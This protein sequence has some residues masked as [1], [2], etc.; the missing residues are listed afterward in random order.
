MPYYEN[1]TH[2]KI[3]DWL[4]NGHIHVFD[5]LPEK[6]EIHKVPREYICNVCA[7]LLGDIFTKWVREKIDDRNA[8]MIEKKDL[9]IDI[10]DEVLKALQESTSVSRKCICTSKFLTF[11]SQ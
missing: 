2:G 7:S 6:R 3:S 9:N 10:D 1:L 8:E 5:Y 4:N 11:H